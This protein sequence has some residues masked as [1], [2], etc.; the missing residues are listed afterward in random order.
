[1]SLENLTA[2]ERQ[3]LELGRI[4]LS[5]PSASKDARRLVKKL[6]PELRFADLD[7]EDQLRA[8]QEANDKRWSDEQERQRK[9]KF[10]RDRAAAH[11]RLRE[12]NLDPTAVEK[13]M[14]D[15]G[16][17]SYDAAAEILESRAALAEPS[18]DNVTP[19]SMPDN[20]ALWKD[21][22]GW[23]RKQAFEAINEVKGRTR[24]AALG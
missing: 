15:M 10:E 5:D 4:L 17:A 14:T 20:K 13:L 22:V 19:M 18:P 16:I 21:P 7:L 24:R 12:R 23:A 8:Q 3:A 6:K 2:E 11:S 9:E 1:M